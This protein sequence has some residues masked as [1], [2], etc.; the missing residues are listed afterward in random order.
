MRYFQCGEFWPTEKE[1]EI[2]FDKEHQD[3]LAFR[4]FKIKE[5]FASFEIVVKML[6]CFP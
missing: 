3:L 2:H 6:I 4:L 1:I 5:S